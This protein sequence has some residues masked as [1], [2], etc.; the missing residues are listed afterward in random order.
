[1][2]IY[3]IADIKKLIARD[4]GCS[5]KD[6]VSATLLSSQIS[7]QTNMYHI[8]EIDVPETI[9]FYIKKSIK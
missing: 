7:N 4:C 3:T 9:N 6:I 2:K 5:E 1:M 8:K